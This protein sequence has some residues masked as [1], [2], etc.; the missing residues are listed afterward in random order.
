MLRDVKMFDKNYLVPTETLVTHLDGT[1][2]LERSPRLSLDLA[3][4]CQ[5]SSNLVAES[6]RNYGASYEEEEEEEA[7]AMVGGAGRP[8][9]RR[10]SDSHAPVAGSSAAAGQVKP[11]GGGQ[12][13]VGVSPARRTR[14]GTS[15][16]AEAEAGPCSPS[17]AMMAASR[18][19]GL[20][21]S[22]PRTSDSG[23]HSHRHSLPTSPEKT[24]ANLR[25]KQQHQQQ[26]TT[27]DAGATGAGG[28][29]TRV[30]AATKDKGKG[31]SALSKWRR[32]LPLL[33]AMRD[34]EVCKVMPGLYVTSPF[35]LALSFSQLCLCPSSTPDASR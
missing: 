29:G 3:A 18:P 32:K 14:A 8:D 27:S 25:R 4:S 11:A 19:Q 16:E 30:A 9:R 26:Q 21:A 7:G 23:L 34:E 20:F 2:S 12:A 17:A 33:K 28:P 22:S 5:H 24:L 35:L 31:K 6:V 15:G 1:Q 10:R 13:S